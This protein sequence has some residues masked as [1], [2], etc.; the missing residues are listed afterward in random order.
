MNRILVYGTLRQGDYN[1]E[2]IANAFGSDSIKKVGEANVK[3]YKL[4]NLGFYPAVN[5]SDNEDDVI[6]CDVLEVSNDAKNFIDRMEFGA[7][8]KLENVNLDGKDHAIYE[9]KSELSEGL[10][11]KSGN[12]FKK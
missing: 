10:R 9:Y 2:R 5:K 11:I 12:W 4:F 8:Y 7:G 1:F 3:N 6:V